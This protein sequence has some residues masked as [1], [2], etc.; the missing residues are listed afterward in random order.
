MN[1]IL[2]LAGLGL[3]FGL[4]FRK[5]DKDAVP[6]FIAI[7]GAVGLFG[8]FA[9]GLC[10]P[11]VMKEYGRYELASM[12]V[13]GEKEGVFLLESA[14]RYTTVY[15]VMIKRADGVY[16]PFVAQPHP[17][18]T[19]II[20]DPNLKDHGVMTV[21]TRVCDPQWEFRFW[22]FSIDKGGYYYEFRVPKGTVRSGIVVN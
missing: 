14:H 9:S 6:R 15:S 16:E 8:A 21:R 11:Q 7:G 5:Q 1:L 19:L 22:G 12:R 4:L 3:V 2:L 10:S 17:G 20:E 18:V 13:L